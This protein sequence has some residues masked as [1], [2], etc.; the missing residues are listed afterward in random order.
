M[1]Q[2]P[3]HN[4]KESRESIE[5]TLTVFD[6]KEFLQEAAIAFFG[7]AN[8]SPEEGMSTHENLLT[9]EELEQFKI[10]CKHVSKRVIN[11]HSLKN[12]GVIEMQGGVT[13]VEGKRGHETKNLHTMNSNLQVQLFNMVFHDL[14]HSVGKIMREGEKTSSDPVQPYLRNLAVPYNNKEAIEDELRG[15]IYGSLYY[16]SPLYNRTFLHLAQ[17]AT[18]EEFKE[19]FIQKTIG[20]A[21]SDNRSALYDIFQTKPDEYKT[22]RALENQAEE[23]GNEIIKNPPHDVIDSL[24]YVWEHK[25]N[26]RVLVDLFFKQIG[27]YLAKLQKRKDY[28][29]SKAPEF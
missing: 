5:K 1:E 16:P 29:I 6:D 26:K 10:F 17:A 3:S 11:A 22:L 24:T 14:S 12:D 20:A 4:Y 13:N 15:F 8:Y 19:N 2:T 9:D 23:I 28:R 7:L 27:E 21:L 18:F 25:D